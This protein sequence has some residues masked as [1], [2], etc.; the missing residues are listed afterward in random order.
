MCNFVTVI[1]GSFARVLVAHY[2]LLSLLILFL[3]SSLLLLGTPFSEN[4]QPRIL[5]CFLS[6]VLHLS[7]I[8][9]LNGKWKPLRESIYDK[10]LRHFFPISSTFIIIVNLF[11]VLWN[12][13]IKKKRKKLLLLTLLLSL[14][15]LL[16]IEEGN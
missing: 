15:L 8:H 12:F 14:L 4:S 6:F 11:T 7:S 3:P 10:G 16:I 2:L 1:L 9:E 5:L 13:R